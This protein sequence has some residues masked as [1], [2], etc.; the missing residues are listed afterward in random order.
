MVVVSGQTQA[1][2]VFSGGAFLH[3]DLVFQVTIT[4]RGEYGTNYV[5][6]EIQVLV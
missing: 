4:Q 3:F 2:P 1:S 5:A 6:R